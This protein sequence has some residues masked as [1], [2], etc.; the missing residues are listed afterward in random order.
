MITKLDARGRLIIPKAIREM[1]G[2][3]EKDKVEI[4]LNGK[5]L[6]ITKGE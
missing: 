6:I 4:R 3:A 5:K 1:M 2:I